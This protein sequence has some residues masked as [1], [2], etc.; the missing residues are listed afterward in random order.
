MD[1]VSIIILNWNRCEELEKTINLIQNQTYQNVEIIVVD[2]ASTDG[3]LDMLKKNFKNIKLICLSSNLGCEEGFNVG[4]VNSS[5]NYILFLDNDASIENEGIEKA[6]VE[7]KNNKKLGVLDIRVFNTFNNKIINE[8]KV[9]PIKNNFTA[10]VVFIKSEVFKKIGLRPSE[11]FIYTSEADISLRVIDAG[12]EIAHT[13]NIVG[14]HRESP[15]KRLSSNFFYYY[16]RNSIWLIWKHYPILPALQETLFLI[17]IN[18][19]RSIINLSFYSF[20][21]GLFE[22]FLLIYKNAIKKRKVLSKWHEARLLPPP[23]LLYKII[24]KKVLRK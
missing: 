5:G 21:K 6:L 8:P 24:I 1:L 2:N 16:T 10:C 19:I 15:K 12:Y 9:W 20:I 23:T 11:Y 14:H 4:I 7:F 22:G 13:T 18:F 3:S 17:I